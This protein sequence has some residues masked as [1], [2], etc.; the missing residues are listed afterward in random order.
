MKNDERFYKPTAARTMAKLNGRRQRR[1][2]SAIV[3]M[4]AHPIH[5]MQVYLGFYALF[6]QAVGEWL[7]EY[8]RSVLT[9]R[10][11]AKTNRNKSYFDYG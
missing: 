4:I 7:A 11:I 10:Q 1:Q 9:E 5:H 6:G 3:S 2:N 8:W